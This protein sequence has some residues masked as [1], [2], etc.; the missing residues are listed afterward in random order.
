M[1]MDTS[2][3]GGAVHMKEIGSEPNVTCVKR[4]SKLQTLG[5]LL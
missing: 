2:L 3:S 4:K 5:F 1:T